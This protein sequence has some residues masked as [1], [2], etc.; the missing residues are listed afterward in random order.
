[1]MGIPDRP[2]ARLFAGI[3][4]FGLLAMTAR[5][6][7]DP[8]LWWHLRTGQWIVET[9]HVPHSDP[10][11]FTRG[12]SPWVSHEWLSEVLFYELWKHGGPGTLIV[13]SSLITTTGFLLLYTRCAVGPA[14]AAA[15]TVLGAVAS[16][17]YWGVR[18][19]M[20]TFTLASLLLWLVERAHNRPRL[21]LWIPPLFLV[22]LNL[23][24]GFALGPAL[25]LL[26]TA[27]LTL[28]VATGATPWGEARPA[29]L[30]LLAV[31]LACLALVPLN[32]SGVQL[33]RYPFDT[34][35]SHA[36]RS[37]IV[38]WFSP[39]FHRWLYMPFLAVFLLLLAALA[40]SRS[41]VKGRVLL[42][43]VFTSFAAFDAVRHIPIFILLAIPVLVSSFPASSPSVA[44]SP[45]PPARSRL[46]PFFGAAVLTL[47]ASFALAQW[48]GLARKQD[49]SED[50]QFPRDAVAYL[51][52]SKRSGKVFAHYDWG[53]YLIW[54]LY[55]QYRVYVDGRA[56]LYG[57]SLLHQF[58]AA[59]HLEKGWHAALDR[60]DVEA[61]LVPPNSALAQA[62]ALDPHWSMPYRDSRAVVFWRA[63]VSPWPTGVV[64]PTIVE[65]AVN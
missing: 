60:W 10:F 64:Q 31:T 1:M 27:G 19:Q 16:A 23:H 22:W 46:S 65:R 47:M 56:D 6:A 15:A 63:P 59:I 28:E 61:V 17:P 8:D 57:D 49:S 40:R 35:R 54:K 52:A 25:L 12:G 26:Y 14:W 42:P 13:F 7:T 34:L 11:S 48:V 62:L 44:L 5:N 50:G 21:L 36:M 24:A 3:L 2:R 4:F 33:Y 45:Q 58:Q 39:N 43:L 53:G 55:P 9:G 20:F 41:Q 37:F 18:P 32:P 38:E 51:Q 29:I 30:R